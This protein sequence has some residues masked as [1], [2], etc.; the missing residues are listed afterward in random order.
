[1]LQ[2]KREF[3]FIFIVNVVSLCWK[4]SPVKVQFTVMTTALF[5]VKKTMRHLRLNILENS[6][7]AFHTRSI[8]RKSQFM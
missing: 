6:L 3:D 8:T 4:S 7:R 1:M 5:K 2:Y